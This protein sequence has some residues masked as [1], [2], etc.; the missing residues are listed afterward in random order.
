MH[1]LSKYTTLC[2]LLLIV[3]LT[4]CGPTAKPAPTA[5]APTAPPAPT[6]TAAPTAAKPPPTPDAVSEIDT[7]LSTQTEGGHFSG[8]V[9]IA[10]NGEVLL[11]KGYGFANRTEQT[12]NTTQTR[13]RIYSNT[14]Q[15]TAMAILMLYAQGKLDLQDPLC[16][17]VAD[18]P[19]AW[20]DVTLHHLLTHTS[21]IPNADPPDYSVPSTPEQLIAL[22]RDRPLDFQPGA[23]FGY[24]NSGYILL[25]YVIEQVSGLAYGEFLKQNI[26]E[27]LD[28]R[29]SG[30]DFNAAELAVGYNHGA[31]MS[32]A[33]P[34]VDASN[35][36]AAGALY[37]TVEDLYRWA[38]ALSTEQL[39]PQELLELIFTIHWAFPSAEFPPGYTE[40]GYGYGWFVAREHGRRE[41]YHV[42]G[43]FGF[44]SLI[45]RYPDEQVTVIFLSNQE[46]IDI[47]ATWD[48]LRQHLF[49]SE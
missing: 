44:V 4:A 29:N 5:A 35:L 20:P 41:S 40:L 14:K 9:L 22:F 11:S 33:M 17:Y 43:F 24:S 42:G 19:G 26:F 7:W 45:D 46:D 49:G 1:R 31:T 30:Y 38:Q 2:V 6:T 27:P 32:E 15:F 10:R 28:M 37:S 25:G 12:P 23:K 13:F 39:I 8:A 34:L 18:C 36:Y 47:G 21:G 3:T 16:K 48:E